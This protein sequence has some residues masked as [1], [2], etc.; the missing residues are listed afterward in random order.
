MSG[1]RAFP[2]ENIDREGS[3]IFAARIECGECEAVDYYSKPAQ[4]AHIVTEQHFRRK[5]WLIGKGPRA[6]R[7]PACQAKKKPNLRIVDMEAVKAEPPREMTRDD[8]RIIMFKLEDVYLKDG[9]T[10]P[11]TDAAVARDLCVPRAWVEKIRDENYGPAG[12]NPE[13]DEFLGMVIAVQTE[14]QALLERAEALA[15]EMK[16]MADRLGG[17]ERTAR[18]LEH[19]IGR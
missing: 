8:R 12:S 16:S 15:L 19:E 17:L 14:R 6:D 5:G 4:K 13:I 9:Y 2:V 10:A 11:W 7:C 1:P 3:R 18:K